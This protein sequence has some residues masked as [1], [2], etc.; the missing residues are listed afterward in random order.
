MLRIVL[1]LC[2]LPRAGRIV[3][4]QTVALLLSFLYWPS[5][6]VTSVILSVSCVTGDKGSWSLKTQSGWERTVKC[7]AQ[8]G[9]QDPL[10]GVIITTAFVR[11]WRRPCWL[12][13]GRCRV[14]FCFLGLSSPV[15]RPAVGAC[16]VRTSCWDPCDSE[17]GQSSH[18]S[19]YHHLWN[20]GGHHYCFSVHWR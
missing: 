20:G 10:M 11:L 5:L 1:R 6:I 9:L 14:R 8:R 17:L 16:R 15:N 2:A 3:I 7:L 13:E 19:L 4:T 12:P 18:L